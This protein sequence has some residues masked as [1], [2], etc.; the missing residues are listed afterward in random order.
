MILAIDIGN[1]STNIGIFDE[2]GN[3]ACSFKM[4]SDKK[5]SEDEYGLMLHYFINNANI[6]NFY[7][8]SPAYNIFLP[9]IVANIIFKSIQKE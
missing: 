7:I 6:K 4:A 1:T 3:L 5:R 8:S 9:K 2:V